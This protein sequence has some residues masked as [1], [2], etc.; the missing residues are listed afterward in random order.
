MGGGGGNCLKWHKCLFTQRFSIFFMDNKDMH[1]ILRRFMPFCN[2]KFIRTYILQSFRL[3]E[4]YKLNSILILN[5]N[6]I[7]NAKM[8]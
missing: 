8:S 4:R 1:V 5:L 3:K 2:L 7:L 6:I